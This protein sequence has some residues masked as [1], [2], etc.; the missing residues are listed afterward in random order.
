MKTPLYQHNC[1]R[2]VF[3]GSYDGS[4]LYYCKATFGH[5][6]GTVIARH[7][8]E[9]IDYNSGLFTAMQVAPDE[10]NRELRALGEAYRRAHRAGHL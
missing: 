1:E 4:D 2:C 7:S 3:L 8:S 9:G 6:Q 10:P 5:P